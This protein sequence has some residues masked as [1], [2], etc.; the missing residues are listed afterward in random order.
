VALGGPA[1][2]LAALASPLRPDTLRLPC[3]VAEVLIAVLNQKGGV[4]K[5]T[6]AV[7]LARWLQLQ[8][9]AVHLADLDPQQ[10]SSFWLQAADEFTVPCT[11]VPADAG[12]AL[13]QL[14]AL[15]DGC[16]VL[17]VDG[18]A[19]LSDATR[20]V[21]LLADLVLTPVQP[22]GADLR[23]AVDVLRLVNQ[24]RRVRGGLPG[25]AVF[26]NRVTKGTRLLQEAR[27]V[28][29]QLD[30]IRAMATTITQRQAVADCFS[31]A[32]T[33]FE[34]GTGPA[35]EAAHEYGRLFAEL[36]NA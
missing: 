13:D 19:G 32:T 34:A 9:R 7:H 29:G 27:D 22:A 1:S 21:M 12:A 31:Q 11:V 10:S 18:P 30:G 20:A 25:A 23:S 36:L 16:D 17:V 24:A 5:S 26:L 14:P 15:A 3:C 33:V 8:G 28:I 2:P 6:T 4:G 35:L